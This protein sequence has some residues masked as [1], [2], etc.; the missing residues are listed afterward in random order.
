MT[1][2]IGAMRSRITLQSPLRVA[3][4]LGGAAILWTDVAEVWAAVDA[5]SAASSAAHDTVVQRAAFRVVIYQR[6]DVRAGWRLLWGDRVLRVVGV[7]DGGGRRIDLMCEE[8]I[9]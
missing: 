8:Q 9:P 3:D 2:A 6:D 7:V 5:L 1:E 4:E